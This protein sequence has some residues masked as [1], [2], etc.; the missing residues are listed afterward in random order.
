MQEFNSIVGGKWW[1]VDFH[2]HTPGSYDYGHG[3]GKQEGTT[4]E[5]FLKCCMKSELDCVVIA[6]HNTL[7]W[8]PKLRSALERMKA[9]P[10]DDYRDITIFPGIEL[11]VQGNIHLLGIFDPEADEET[12]KAIPF[13]VRYN[14]TIDTT[15]MAINQ[16]I[17]VIT[18]NNGIA[19]PAHVDMPSGLFFTGTKPTIIRAALNTEK[20]LALEVLGG[21]I[22]NATLKES[23]QKLSYVVGS[24]SHSTDTIGDKYTWV[25]MGTPNIEAMRLALF[26]NDDGVIRYNKIDGNPNDIHGK[27]YIKSLEISN[28]KYIGRK[29]T[30]KVQF[31]PWLNSII[32]G[33]GSGKSSVLKFIRLILDREN[34]L[35]E[36]LRS[37]Y[38]DFMKVPNNREDLG[39][40]QKK[41]GEKPGT[42]VKMEICVDGVDHLLKWEDHKI[43]EY[44]TDTNSW[45]SAQAVKERFPVRM[46]SQKQLFEM[47]GDTK[48]LFQILDSKWDYGAWKDEVASLVSEYSNTSRE[49]Y[50]LR[51][52]L[53]RLNHLKVQLND[54]MK[55]IKV[56]ETD[57]T[58]AVLEKREQLNKQHKAVKR[59]YGNYAGF[60]EWIKEFE[61]Y[62]HLKNPLIDESIDADT[63][64]VIRTWSNEVSGVISEIENTLIKKNELFISL[65]DWIEALPLSD[66]I[67]KNEVELKDVINHL[68]EAG[69]DDI[70]LYA[71]LIIQKEQI[72]KDIANLV[73]VSNAI[74]ECY[75]HMEEL[76]EK[77]RLLINKRYDC[78]NSVIQQ[79][80]QIG[81]LRL[82]LIPF[83]DISSNEKEFRNI[84]RREGAYF[85]KEIL[86]Y[87]DE[88][89]I[90]N[91]GILYF[92]T[93]ENDVNTQ[94]ISLE[95]MKAKVLNSTDTF[96]KRFS[97]YLYKL[98]NDYPDSIAELEL[99]IPKDALKLEI[100]MNRKGKAAYRS[101]E[102]GSPGQRTSAVLSLILGISTMPIIIDQP[103]DDLDTRNITDIVVSSIN[104]MKKNQQIIVVTHNPN[105]VVNTNSEQ[106]IQ[107]DFLRGQIVNSCSGALQSHD[108]RDAICEV[109]EGGKEA[110]EKRYYRIFRA[111]EK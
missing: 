75:T 107:L 26:D 6:D 84:I 74:D 23:K 8:V 99:W 71:E 10:D 9:N 59:V 25:K 31:S 54:V 17:D 111:L 5:E 34:E 98:F 80:N 55:K 56:F 92:M 63:A 68:K 53:N 24:D 14:K 90:S 85:S 44:N 33:R 57:T 27:T 11:N 65:D 102:A 3:D 60:I 19:I 86:E 16:V 40:L 83:G 87:N 93:K 37:E 95:E 62:T 47:T 67:K 29:N 39:M 61:K 70:D 81:S 18:E 100:N 30:Y 77:W 49:L 108:V 103:E 38:S 73:D 94:L 104:E 89:E 79:W 52:K 7:N 96:G 101:I 13:L 64:E 36:S 58:K 28:G 32:G 76:K 1:K 110:L 45:E 72:E 46:F 21:E 41:N 97:D 43:L 66:Q 2:L 20:L 88:G 105:I 42:V 109:M 4:P 78:R 91:K 69:V 12:L 50:N 35:P 51:G 106:V 15:D 22:E 48:M 82:S